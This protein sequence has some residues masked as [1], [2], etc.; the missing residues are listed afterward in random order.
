MK[1]TVYDIKL[2]VGQ[3]WRWKTSDNLYRVTAVYDDG[4]HV[5]LSWEH[6]GGGKV[7]NY[8]MGKEKNGEICMTLAQQAP[9]E[10]IEV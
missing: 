8:W 10:V 6:Q 7:T 9:Q 1:L 4:M 5:D 3:L 2:Q